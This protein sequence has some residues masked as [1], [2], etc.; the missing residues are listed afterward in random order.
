MRVSRFPLSTTR[1]T[2]A[3]AEIVSHQLMLRSGMIRRLAAGLYTWQPLGLRVLRKVEHIVREEMDRAGALEV[4]MPAIQ[5]AELW[6]ESG[7]WEKYGPELLRIDDRHQRRYCYGP[8]HE[9]VITDLF[10]REIHSYRQLPINWYQIQT[11]FRDETRPRFGV[12]RAREFIMKDAY[13]F[14]L[15]HAS[16]QESYEAMHQAYCRIFERA[17]LV[18]RAVEADTGAIGGNLSHE[19]MVL[20]S[21]GEDAIAVCED[22]GYAANVELAEAVPP[23][24]PRPE[25]R[26]TMREVATPEQRTIEAV[27]EYLEVPAQRTV[28]TLVVHGPDNELVA[29]VLRGDH[30]L[31]ELKAEK[32]P[33]VDAPLRFAE[34]EEVERRLGCPFGSLGPVGLEGV[35]VIADRTAVGTADFVCGANRPGYHLTGVNWGRDLAEPET[36]DLRTVEEGDPSPDGGGTLTIRRGIEVGHVFQLGTTYSEAMGAQVLDEDGQARTVTMGCYGI[37]VSRVVAAAIEQNHDDAGIC[38]PEPLAP[39]QVALVAIPANNTAV[40]EEAGRVY[41]E[42]RA[43]GYE[44]LYDDRDVRPGVKFAD[45]ELIG[46]PHRVVVSER[47][48]EAGEVEYRG[49][50]DSEVQRFPRDALLARLRERVADAPH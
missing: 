44:V 39:F 5:P 49:R 38:W 46:I 11:K 41:E 27:S 45:M 20:A 43:E 17:G 3:D 32:H 35:H 28:K 6:E 13:S 2:P 30:E 19:F 16:L 36:A 48:I 50:R 25:P 33:R 23:G 18:F 7:R 26:E 40:L 29:L 1:E 10:R 21:S 47:G 22:S 15:D 34:P 42:L 14:H 37:G 4:L 12:M 9:E 24:G 8:T 31:N